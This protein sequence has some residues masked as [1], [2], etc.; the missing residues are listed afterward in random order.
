MTHSVTLT[1]VVDDGDSHAA[2][3]ERV[4]QRWVSPGDFAV[5]AFEVVDACPPAGLCQG[6]PRWRWQPCASESRACVE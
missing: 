4:R 2:I 1:R 5:R 6:V 3:V